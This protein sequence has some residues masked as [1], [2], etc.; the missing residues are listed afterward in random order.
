MFTSC[1]LLDTVPAMWS[2]CSLT[3]V[4]APTWILPPNPAPAQ[5]TTLPETIVARESEGDAF[6]SAPG[7]APEATGDPATTTAAA[8]NSTATTIPADR[9]ALILNDP[10]TP[11]SKP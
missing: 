7:P 1:P 5:E 6:N 8:M 9:R 4:G 2:S 10:S 11:A 3:F